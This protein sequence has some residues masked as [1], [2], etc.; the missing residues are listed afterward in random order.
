[1]I[2]DILTSAGI[3]IHYLTKAGEIAVCCPFCGES[4]FRCGIN[5]QRGVAHCYNCS[6]ACGTE[7]GIVKQLSRVL[8]V[9][10]RSIRRRV[11]RGGAVPPV[12]RAETERETVLSGLPDGYEP[13]RK[14]S[15]E[16]SRQARAYLE[17]RQ[18]SLLQIVRHKIGY[19]AAGRLS[20]RVIFPVIAEDNMVHGSVARSFLA[21]GKPKYLNSPGMK[22]LWNAKPLGA[23]AVVVEGVM[24][25]L[26]VET[27]LLSVRDTQAVARLGSAITPLQMDQLKEFERVTILPDQDEAGVKGAIELGHRCA[28]R[29]IR[30]FV[31]VP[32]AMTERDPGDMSTSEIVELLCDAV[33]WNTAAELKLKLSATRRV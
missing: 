14:A 26:R 3:E 22:M 16:V 5:F 32:P 25:A 30:T 8:R 20:Y 1:M 2:V 11:G 4:R 28:A 33:L 15:T 19:A 23:S 21:T 13:F 7:A 29:G 31:C 17:S 18:I 24:D 27:A 9:P 12:V 10:L 6:W